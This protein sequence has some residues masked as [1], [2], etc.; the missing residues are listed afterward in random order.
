MLFSRCLGKLMLG[1]I[2]VLVGNGGKGEGPEGNDP[3]NC[4]SAR[5]L[6]VFVEQEGAVFIGDRETHRAG[7]WLKSRP[8]FPEMAESHSDQTTECGGF[9]AA[10]W[11]LPQ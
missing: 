2:E 9:K 6:G 5:A 11:A 3:L 10:V 8:S 7:V 4:Q 1:T